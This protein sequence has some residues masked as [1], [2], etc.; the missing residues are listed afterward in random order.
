MII[1]WQDVYDEPVAQLYY[2]MENVFNND[3]FFQP[4]G[5]T[6]RSPQDSYP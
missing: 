6:P 1:G 4:K 5:E 3:Y 2:R